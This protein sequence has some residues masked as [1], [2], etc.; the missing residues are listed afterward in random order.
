MIAEFQS[1]TYKEAAFERLNAASVLHGK[2]QYI[3][4]HYLAGVAVE[5]MFRA[6]HSRT[7]KPFDERHDLSMLVK[8]SGYLDDI[9]VNSVRQVLV[10]LAVVIAQWRN[11]HR[12][13]TSTQLRKFLKERKL[14]RINGKDIQGDFV[15]ERSRI[16]LANASWLVHL[17]VKQWER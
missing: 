6:Y 8:S 13:R 11:N 5:C 9:Q 10:V 2:G 17:G 7:G 15:K 4:A 16:L 14:D 1:T 3:E 12:Y